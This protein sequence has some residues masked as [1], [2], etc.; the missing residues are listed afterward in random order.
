MVWRILLG[1]A[2]YKSDISI[3]KII[4]DV[5]QHIFM[6]DDY[7]DNIIRRRLGSVD[8][9][10]EDFWALLIY[11]ITTYTSSVN[12]AKE[13]NRDINNVYLGLLY[14]ICY[15]M[16]AGSNRAVKQLNQRFNKN[17]GRPPSKDE[18]KR[19]INNELSEKAIFGLVKSSSTSIALAQADVS[20]DSLYFKLT[21]LLENQNTH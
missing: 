18:L 13:Y 1:R 3:D 14:Y 21:A 6:V 9:D 19:I 7:V 16:I 10:I 12:N 17:G 4:D 20:N 2:M 11:I 5:K 8:I 15:D